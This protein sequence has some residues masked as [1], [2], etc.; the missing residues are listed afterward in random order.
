MMT[1]RST[2]LTALLTGYWFEVR[3]LIPMVVV[4]LW[5]RASLAQRQDT[6]S[7]QSPSPLEDSA[8]TR[9]DDETTST[10]AGSS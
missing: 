7:V 5:L 9:S 1:L 2:A 4:E 3:L 6:S 8:S 10:P